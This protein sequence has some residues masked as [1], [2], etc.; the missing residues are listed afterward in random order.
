M[1]EPKAERVIEQ[2]KTDD[3]ILAVLL[4]GSRARREATERSDTDLCLVLSPEKDTPDERIRVRLAYLPDT[5]LDVRLFQQLPLAIRQRVLK[6]GVILYCRD[7]PRLY[8][9]AYHTA[10]AFELFRPYYV[11]SLRA[12]EHAGS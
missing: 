3:S 6:D 12:I 1:M 11:R 5:G 10:K 4:F 7:R 2:A 8:D 9:L